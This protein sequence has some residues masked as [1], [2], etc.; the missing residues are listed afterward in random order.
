MKKLAK[1]T[2]AA[3]IF[4]APALHSLEAANIKDFPTVAVMDFGN[5]AITSRGL[6][7][8]D[9]TMATEYAIYQLS[10]S[11]WFDLI[12]YEQLS[13]LAKMQNINNSG[14]IDPSTA[15]PLGRIAGAKFIVVG[16][17]TGLTTKENLVGVNAYNVR[18]GNAAHVV[19]ANVSVRIVDVETGRIVAAGIGKGSS[20]STIT[21]VGFTK[22]RTKRNIRAENIG[23]TVVNDVRDEILTRAIDRAN[24]TNSSDERNITGGA[25]DVYNQNGSSQSRNGGSSSNRAFD[26][27]SS[28]QNGTSGQTSKTQGNQDRSYDDTRDRNLS[29]NDSTSSSASYD[30]HGR[31]T[32]DQNGYTNTDHAEGY[33]HLHTEGGPAEGVVTGSG[34][35]LRFGGTIWN[36]EAKYDMEASSGESHAYTGNHYDNE[37]TNHE[38][39]RSDTDR[40]YNERLDDDRHIED[41]A[42]DSRYTENNQRYN[43]NQSH[44]NRQ[45]NDGQY[46]NR[47][48]NKY[49]DNLTHDQNYYYNNTGGNTTTTDDSYHDGQRY[50]RNN[51]QTI[52]TGNQYATYDEERRDYSIMIGTVEVSDVQVRNAISKAVRDAIY[53]KTGLM[54]TLNGGKQ[55]KIKTGF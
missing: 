7:G 42:Q 21:E 35:D 14:F 4:C 22:Y 16:Y 39:V 17:V 1:I 2:A 37:Q 43:D 28:N 49:D 52:T 20:T 12:D 6:R 3:L 30:Q 54:T 18:A 11:G 50:R 31:Q 46:E 10:N 48:D 32:G 38:Q 26:T 44:N 24:R 45:G 41:H 9:M 23:Q 15:V 34:K 25:N 40:N 27:G 13:T 8:H 55:L 29:G 36:R 51:T 5:K 33:S 19:N 53:G 47:A